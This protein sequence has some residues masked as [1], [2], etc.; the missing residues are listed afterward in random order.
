MSQ[1]PTLASCLPDNGLGNFSQKPATAL[2]KLSER[3]KL[4]LKTSARLANHSE[5]SSQIPLCST[6]IKLAS[7]V[8]VSGSCLADEGFS[9]QQLYVNMNFNSISLMRERARMVN[10]SDLKSGEAWKGL[11]NEDSFFID[12][13]KLNFENQEE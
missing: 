11:V 8:P 9:S 5:F 10:D 4:T 1:E 2:C 12:V 6:D 7:S 3:S 13:N